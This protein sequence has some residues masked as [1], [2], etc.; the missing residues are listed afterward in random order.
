MKSNKRKIHF[1]EVHNKSISDF[2]C[3]Y[4]GSYDK[5]RNKDNGK[6]CFGLLGYVEVLSYNGLL[7]R[8][9][10]V[11][12]LAH[13]INSVSNQKGYYVLKTNN[14]GN[15]IDFQLVKIGR[16]IACLMYLEANNLA[17][18]TAI[19]FAKELAKKLD[20]KYIF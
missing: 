3:Y 11:S 16:K 10:D 19:D 14:K 13:I 5:P 20:C 15:L 2:S 4:I 1:I 7:E 17:S 8:G 12:G 9:Q 6:K 18:K